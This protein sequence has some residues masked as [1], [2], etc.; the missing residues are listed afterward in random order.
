[1]TE[2]IHRISWQ[3][4]IPL[5]HQVLWPNHPASFC[6]VGGDETALHFGVFVQE[7]LVCVAS[8]FPHETDIQLRKFATN[9]AFQ[10]RGIG[11]HLIKHLFLEAKK[12]GADEF[13]CYSRKSACS[14]YERFGMTQVGE[15]FD[16]AGVLFIKM[17]RQ[18]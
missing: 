10:G 7:T 6:H 5:R 2:V 3:E 11:S 14:F 4:T 17:S 9:P 16:R 12:N 18:L 1:M 13:W 15:P 8:L